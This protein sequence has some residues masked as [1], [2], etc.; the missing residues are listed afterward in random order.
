MLV[1]LV[2]TRQCT[3]RT[4]ASDAAS[5]APLRGTALSTCTSPPPRAR[6]RPGP[7]RR[8]RPQ[9]AVC[10]PPR[11]TLMRYDEI[12]RQIK[13]GHAVRSRPKYAYGDDEAAREAAGK[14]A[15]LRA[16]KSLSTGW[17][18]RLKKHPHQATPAP[19][20]AKCSASF[21]YGK[22]GAGHDN[23]CLAPSSYPLRAPIQSARS[24][25]PLPCL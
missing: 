20:E 10:V 18:A 21:L 9:A 3:V 6:G 5:L 7:A 23:G 19:G 12:S 22:D 8:R 2:L 4:R 24:E 15:L 25:R 14:A 13:W 16:K 11:A 1:P 17:A